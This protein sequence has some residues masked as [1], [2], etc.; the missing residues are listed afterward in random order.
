M[1][2]KTKIVVLHMKEL[3]YTGLFILLGVL[4]IILLVIMFNPKGEKASKDSSTAYIPGV[5]TTSLILQGSAVDLEVVVNESQIT[6]IR[7]INMEESVP[8]LYPL[9]EPALDDLAQQIYESQDLS[10]VKYNNENRY[11][12]L[13]LLEAISNTLEKASLNLVPETE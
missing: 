3:I 6:S 9:M 5:Y 8:T 13:M 12:S 4:F 2:S 10:T 1:H 7:F 11:T